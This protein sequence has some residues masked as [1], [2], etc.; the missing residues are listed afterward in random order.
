MTADIRDRLRR[1]GVHKGVGHLKPTARPRTPGHGLQ[2]PDSD[3]AAPSREPTSLHAEH[4]R[5]ASNLESPRGASNLES[6]PLWNLELE[7]AFG[8]AFVRRTVF[9]VDH[10]HGGSTLRRAL[11]LPPD[12]VA[13]L[14]DG[15]AI[16]LRD[17]IF[18]D[19]ET[20]GLVGGTGTLVFLVGAGYFDGP[21]TFVVD[22][23]FLPDP[24]QE[25]GMLAALDEFINR[26]SAV[27]TFN[28]RGFDVPL[29]E[30]RFILS[31]IAPAFGERAHL[32]LLLPARRAWRNDLGSCSLSSL[33]FHMLDVRRDQQDIPGFL[34]PD[35]YREYLH[36]GD[37]AEMQRVMYHNLHDILSMVTLVERLCSAVSAPSS[38]G[39]YL[40]AG[41]Y[42]EN[43]GRLDEAEQIYTTALAT[44]TT[45]AATATTAA[46]A[47]L[48]LS[49]RRV[50]ARLA[51]CLKRQ[52]RTEQAAPY[53]R[54]LAAA[55]D[56]DAC[57]ELAKH[58]E[59]RAMDCEQALA[60]ARAALALSRDAQTRGEINH[61]VDRLKRKLGQ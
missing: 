34:I 6:L 23:Y 10:Q 18:L 14:N 44:T 55:G 60:W 58:Y 48:S 36:K 15:A 31:R 25:A 33:E 54:Q 29:L 28:G 4:P 49:H 41:L 51:A 22:Q 19:T 1:L 35:L 13:R 7:S 27:V 8:L 9:H 5:G 17:A 61:R 21:D 16:D 37:P 24:G 32:D 2:M 52:D 20:T 42:L 50:L 47:H 56:L 57:L 45:A 12:L 53:W 3:T 59:W 38:M 30:T 26:H 39:E 43:R 11:D 40:A 46:A